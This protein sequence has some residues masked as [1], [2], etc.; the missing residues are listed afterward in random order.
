ME[1]AFA[2][3]QRKGK[4]LAKR[5]SSE[6]VER[7]PKVDKAKVPCNKQAKVVSSVTWPL[8]GC[9][10]GG[11]LVLRQTFLLLLCKSCCSYAN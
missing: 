8:N 11:D 4:Q 1:S 6:S 2:P 10:A 5:L 3:K 9:E 7:P